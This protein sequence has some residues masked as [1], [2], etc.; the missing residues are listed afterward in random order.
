[1]DN[2]IN[3]SIRTNCE[4]ITK[5]VAVLA[6]S[7]RVDNFTVRDS[8]GVGY[9]ATVCGVADKSPVNMKCKRGGDPTPLT[10]KEFWLR[11]W[12]SM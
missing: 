8:P 3:G 10:K 2:T 12:D 7:P 5:A 4:F 11:Y 6:D 1:L 9:I